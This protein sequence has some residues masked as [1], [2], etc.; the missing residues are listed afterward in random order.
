MQAVYPKR[1]RGPCKQTELPDIL[2][3]E[4]GAWHTVRKAPEKGATLLMATG[5]SPWKQCQ[6][7]A[8]SP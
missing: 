2:N 3:A 1:E 5:A 6:N 4:P 8:R 7:M